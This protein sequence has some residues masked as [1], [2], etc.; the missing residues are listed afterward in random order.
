MRLHERVHF[1]I[2][3]LLL[4]RQRSTLPGIGSAI[5][6]YKKIAKL[7]DKAAPAEKH[8]TSDRAGKVE[9]LK[10]IQVSLKVRVGGQI[11]SVLRHYKRHPCT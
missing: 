9:G 6:V 10:V 5:K 1:H 4:M 2:Y 11:V 3:G 7:P 8:S